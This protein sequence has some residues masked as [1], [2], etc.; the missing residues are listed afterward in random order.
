MIISEKKK[1]INQPEDVAKIIQA[2]LETENDISQEQ[3]HFWV[4][5]LNIKNVIQYI[6]LV[7]LGTVSMTITHPREIFRLA[8]LKGCYSIICC[9]N[10][11]SQELTPSEEDIKTYDRI[12]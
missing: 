2:I 12:N 3:E 8:I 1:K 4:I 10:H 9:H 11:P 7:S 5:G 6:D